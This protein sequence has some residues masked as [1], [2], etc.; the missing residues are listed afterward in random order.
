VQRQVETIDCTNQPLLNEPA[1]PSP[2]VTL[3]VWRDPIHGPALM[4]PD[5][6]HQLFVTDSAAD[7]HFAESFAAWDQA[8]LQH[9]AADFGAALAPMALSFNFFFADAVGE[10]AYFHTGRY[11]VRPS[12][13]DP[14]LPIPGSGPYDWTGV[15][16]YEDLPH[17]INPST[18]A[19]ANWNNKP[20]RDWYSKTTLAG[21]GAPDVWGIDNQVVP[22]QAALA[23]TTRET[24]TQFQQIPQN[25]AY[26]DNEAL[27]LR[28][29][30]VAALSS[31]RD[32]DARL[33][34]LV[35]YL[36]AWDSSRNHVDSAGNYSTPAIVFFDRWLEHMVQDTLGP[37]LGTNLASAYAG[38][39]CASSPCHY[40]SVD[41]LDAPT[42]KAQLGAYELLINALAGR[43]TYAWLPPTVG[44]RTTAVLTAARQAADEIQATQGTTVTTWT[45]PA[46]VARF[47]PLGAISV[48]PV[49]PLP[50]RGSYA[51][52]IEPIANSTGT[53]LRPVTSR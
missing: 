6:N 52:V 50:N 13:V 17:D 22:L 39:N 25:V 14:R 31:S 43:T 7:G 36:S 8:T 32:T 38:L 53:L 20:A 40:V 46:E 28:P 1:C 2:A 12:T 51:Q 18:G 15:E 4:D 10:I 37:A 45:E 11:P 42:Y 41:N 29:L 16:R 3:T 33:R 30:L 19:L 5:A 48:P 47:Q 23:A 44:G 9:G 35:P 49:A 24:M 21:S 27:P 34:G 26:L